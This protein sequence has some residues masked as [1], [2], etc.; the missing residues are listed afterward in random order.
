MQIQTII[1]FKKRV[2]WLVDNVNHRSKIR[3]KFINILFKDQNYS[4]KKPILYFRDFGSV[5]LGP[6]KVI[7]LSLLYFIISLKY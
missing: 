6:R 3:F 1:Q 4:A 2:F 7:M 5:R